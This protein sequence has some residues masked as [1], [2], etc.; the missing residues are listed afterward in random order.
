MI[1]A[2]TVFTRLE[3]PR[4]RAATVL[5][6]VVGVL[7][8]ALPWAAVAHDPDPVLSGGLFAQD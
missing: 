1:P 7:S 3:S 8:L 5:L 2:R 6:V 4:P